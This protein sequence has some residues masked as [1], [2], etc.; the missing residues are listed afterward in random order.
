MPLLSEWLEKKFPLAKRQSLKRMVEGGR[1]LVD[2]RA[3]KRL[4]ESFIEGAKILV[5][6]RGE[7]EAENFSGAGSGEAAARRGFEIVFEDRDLLVVNKP[8]GVLTSTVPG[9]KRPTL[10]AMVRADVARREPMARVGLIHRLDRD[11]AGLLVFSKNNAA[12]E[13]LKRQFF[14]HRVSRV[15]TAIVE[16][17]PKPTCG[18]IETRLVE[19]TDGTV[20]S[21]NVPQRGERAI[22]HYET[23][24]Q[25]KG[26]AILRVKLETGRK[27]QIRVHLSE[28]GWAIVGDGVYGK[29]EDGVMRLCA[30][31]LEVEHPRSGERMKFT[32]ET[33]WEKE[34]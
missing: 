25:V 5:A 3:A 23:V 7:K 27:H 34:L 24:R 28:R 29:A 2:G 13:S 6:R 12:Y 20:H 26:R 22:T 18:R 19:R 11:A 15:Y 1:V 8:P 4:G 10:L 9:E 16:G 21:T 14:H 17:H 31:E 33:G 30:T 32:V